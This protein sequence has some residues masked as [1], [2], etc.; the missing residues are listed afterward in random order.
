[1]SYYR[2]SQTHTSREARAP[3]VSAG[4]WLRRRF[5]KPDPTRTRAGGSPLTDG[6]DVQDV[7]EEDVRLR[8]VQGLLQTL[9]LH[10]VRHE[11]AQAFVVRGLGSDQL[12]HGLRR[13]KHGGGEPVVTSR[14]SPRRR[15]STPLP[16]RRRP[17]C[18]RPRGARTSARQRPARLCLKDRHHALL[19]RDTEA[20]D[21]LTPETQSTRKPKRSAVPRS[22]S[23]RDGWLRRS[24]GAEWL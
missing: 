4:P 13:G 8:R 17:V 21:R 5:R 24:P 3:Q 7:G 10:E 9:I 12:E 11:Q 6:H 18:T 20:G 1:M 15:A 14:A 22:P 2:S 23:S 19:A 16:A